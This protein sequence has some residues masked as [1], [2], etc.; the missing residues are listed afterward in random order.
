MVGAT[1]NVGLSVGG[2]LAGLVVGVNGTG[3]Y[4]VLILTL[5]PGLFT[6]LYAMGP[7]LPWLV[8]AALVLAAGM[9]VAWLEPR[10]PAP[11]VRAR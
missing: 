4:P 11:T 8:L 6:V 3:G 5:A 10:L 7:A 1:Q 9:L 2:L